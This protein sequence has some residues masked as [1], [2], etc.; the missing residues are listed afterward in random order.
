LA[1]NALG[2]FGKRVRCHACLTS[3]K[4]RK[5]WSDSGLILR[6]SPRMVR[7]DRLETEGP[8]LLLVFA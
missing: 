7:A 2:C 6:I 4:Q 8:C 1:T 5:Q 3:F